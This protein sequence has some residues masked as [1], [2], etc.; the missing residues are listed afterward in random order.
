MKLSFEEILFQWSQLHKHLEYMNMVAAW[1][2]KF[3]EKIYWEDSNEMLVK[4]I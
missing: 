3:K 4:K 2:R 1:W